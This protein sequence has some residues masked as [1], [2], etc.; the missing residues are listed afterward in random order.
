MPGCA[1]NP[2][3]QQHCPEVNDRGGRKRAAGPLGVFNGRK[4]RD[5]SDNNELQSYQRAGRG[6]HDHIEVFPSGEWRHALA[7]PG[8]YS[9]LR[10]S[11]SIEKRYFTS[12]LS[13]LA[14]ASFTFCM[15]MTSTSAVMLCFP[16]KSS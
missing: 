7:S 8:P 15:G 1:L 12:D 6:A 10:D 4:F 9:D 14:Y 3:Q 13:S 11:M 5:E 2:R 16:Q